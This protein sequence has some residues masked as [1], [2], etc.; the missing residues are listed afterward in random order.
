MLKFEE[1]TFESFKDLNLSSLSL[2]SFEHHGMDTDRAK[3][4]KVYGSYAYAVAQ[5]LNDAYA[6]NMEKVENEDEIKLGPDMDGET[7]NYQY[8]L[9]RKDVIDGLDN[10]QATLKTSITIES[11]QETTL[12]TIQYYDI[13]NQLINDSLKHNKSIILAND[14]R[15]ITEE[16]I[17]RARELVGLNYTVSIVLVVPNQEQFTDVQDIHNSLYELLKDSPRVKLYVTYVGETK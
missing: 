2:E 11:K 4:V 1:F 7:D 3:T 14:Y 13:S 5:A 8:Y 9:N 10:S 17:Q 12:N 6:K 16:D 15:F